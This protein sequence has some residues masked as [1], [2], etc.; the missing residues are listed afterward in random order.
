VAESIPLLSHPHSSPS[1][2][3]P[4][5]LVR[6]VRADRGIGC[7][8]VPAICVLDFDGDLTDWLNANGLARPCISWAC[9]HTTMSIVSLDGI[10][11]GII[12]RTIGGSYA[13]LVAEQ[14]RVSGARVIVGLT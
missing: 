7:E 10:D 14:L 3:T 8:D 5:A 4:E 12:P 13:V 6:A 9:F 11:C 1:A 2:F